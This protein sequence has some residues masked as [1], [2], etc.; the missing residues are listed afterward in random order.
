MLD[1]DGVSIMGNLEPASSRDLKSDVHQLSDLEA[2]ET[3]PRLEPVKFRYR[4]APQEQAVGFIAEDLPDLVSNRDKTGLN[5]MDLVAVLTKV[6]QNQQREIDALK[7]R[8]DGLVQVEPG[9]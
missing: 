9:R 7:S 2:M 5:P 1:E 6:V 8:V 3:F 4:G